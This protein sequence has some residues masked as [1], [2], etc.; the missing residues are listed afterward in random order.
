MLLTLQCGA[1]GY[2]SPIP[3]LKTIALI[4]TFGRLTLTEASRAYLVE[5][6]WYVTSPTYPRAHTPSFH[7]LG[8]T[9]IN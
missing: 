8:L 7:V 1:V 3:A 9:G 4:R 6:H 5:P 2:I